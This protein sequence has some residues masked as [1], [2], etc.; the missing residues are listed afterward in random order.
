[1]ASGVSTSR[2]EAVCSRVVREI[3]ARE[4]VDVADL[5]EPLFDVVDPDALE[6]VF[7][8]DRGYVGFPYHG[9]WVTVHANGHVTVDED[10]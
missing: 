7:V 2:S 5:S 8:T 3:A 4:D 6:S 1:M 9:Y 10:G